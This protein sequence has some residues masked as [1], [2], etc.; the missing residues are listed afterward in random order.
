MKI[1]DRYYIIIIINNIIIII[2]SSTERR[3][4]AGGIESNYK[5]DGDLGSEFESR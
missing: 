1:R 5:L 4:G 3:D 2:I